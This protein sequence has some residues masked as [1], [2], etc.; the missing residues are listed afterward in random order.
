M[1]S[2]IYCWNT[3]MW[4]KE[5]AKSIFMM[6]KNKLMFTETNHYVVSQEDSPPLRHTSLIYKS[7]I[8]LEVRMLSINSQALRR[9]VLPLVYEKKKK[10]CFS[11]YS[12]LHII[13][14]NQHISALRHLEWFYNW[15]GHCL[16]CHSI[17]LVYL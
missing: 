1:H 13:S 8:F 9:L 5:K 4:N 2:I 7:H 11:I 16:T 10:N 14:W 15:T 6:R 12:C 17:S 3:F